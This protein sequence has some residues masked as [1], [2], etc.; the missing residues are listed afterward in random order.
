MSTLRITVTLLVVLGLT[1]CASPS[2]LFFR[3]TFMG[4]ASNAY[5]ESL[6]NAEGWMCR[7][8]SIGSVVRAY[9]GSPDRWEAWLKL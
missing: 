6:V 7:G 4:R 2:G 3:N 5:D 1:G 8:A 9:G